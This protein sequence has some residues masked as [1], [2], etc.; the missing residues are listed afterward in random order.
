[1][2]LRTKGPLYNVNVELYEEQFNAGTKMEYYRERR[3][4]TRTP[5]MSW[6]HLVFWTAICLMIGW[7]L[8]EAIIAIQKG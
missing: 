2:G 7:L 3:Q 6:P 5:A 8:A 1:M 4:E